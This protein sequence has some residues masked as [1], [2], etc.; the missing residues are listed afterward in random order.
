MISSIHAG[1]TVPSFKMALHMVRAAVPTDMVLDFA[2]SQV[3]QAKACHLAQSRLVAQA[4]E[5][6]KTEWHA[7]GH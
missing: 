5:F 3:C 2:Q 6:L 4:T 1:H 7:I